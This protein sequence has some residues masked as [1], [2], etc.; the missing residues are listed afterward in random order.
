[1][2][3]EQKPVQSRILLPVLGAAGLLL[4]GL[5]VKGQFDQHAEHAK[6]HGSI[7]SDDSTPSA[8]FGTLSDTSAQ[9]KSGNA[10]TVAS[11]AVP[12]A[13]VFPHNI[14]TASY[15][16]QRFPNQVTPQI[17]KLPPF[18]EADKERAAREMFPEYARMQA[19][20]EAERAKLGIKAENE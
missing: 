15:V 3:S 7:A 1:M 13:T 11:A 16:A 18:T 8:A 9:A 5:I 10:L 2:I 17:I 14:D 6:K 4:V 12:A 20:A 19:Q